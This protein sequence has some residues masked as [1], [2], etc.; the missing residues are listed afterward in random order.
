[1][2]IVT[3]T[4]YAFFL[5]D[6]DNKSLHND[7]YTLVCVRNILLGCTLTW[8]SESCSSN[9]ELAIWVR[10]ESCWNRFKPTILMVSAFSWD[11]YKVIQSAAEWNIHQTPYTKGENLRQDKHNFI[12]L[13]HYIMH[14]MNYMFWMLW[15]K[16][17]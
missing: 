12:I 7:K 2:Q 5:H 15:E 17:P 9:E 11:I 10:W 1:M 6:I 3:N 13:C 14:S 16:T 4:V 8:S